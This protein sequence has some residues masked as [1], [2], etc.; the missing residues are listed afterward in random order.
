GV[1]EHPRYHADAVRAA[2]VIGPGREEQVEDLDQAAAFDPVE[3]PQVE[4]TAGGGPVHPGTLLGPDHDGGRL[5][6]VF[7]QV[8]EGHAEPQGPRPQRL[9]GRVTPALLQV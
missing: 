4:L 5:P 3:Q 2:E 8:A 9:D 1:Y 7:P 6:P